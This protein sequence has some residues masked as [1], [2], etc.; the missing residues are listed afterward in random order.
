[1]SMA[2]DTFPQEPGPFAGSESTLRLNAQ[3]AMREVE[4]RLRSEMREAKDTLEAT[5]KQAQ[6]RASML[7]TEIE[8]LKGQLQSSKAEDPAGAGGATGPSASPAG[9]GGVAA[10]LKSDKAV[11]A[12][13]LLSSG[14]ATRAGLEKGFLPST[15]VCVCVCVRVL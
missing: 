11:T 7:T 5:N 10:L 6:M 3:S 15:C 4:S 14:S 2:R 8:Y 1:M 9:A 12:E 13:G